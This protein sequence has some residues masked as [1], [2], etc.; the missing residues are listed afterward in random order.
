LRALVCPEQSRWPTPDV[1]VS[2]KGDKPTAK[3]L[4]WERLHATADEARNRVAKAWSDI[5]E[6]DSD[7]DLSAEGKARQCA[8]WIEIIRI[9]VVMARR[10]IPQEVIA[11]QDVR[12]N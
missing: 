4:H 7:A 10:P 8:V 1:E 6:I 9:S 5:D 12:R 2:L 3:G 11:G